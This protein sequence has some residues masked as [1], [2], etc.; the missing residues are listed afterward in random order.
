MARAG[1]HQL[2]AGVHEAP[3]LLP[4]A[5]QHLAALVQHVPEGVHGHERRDGRARRQAHAGAADA[6]LAPVI[7]SV[8][9]PHGRA[10]ARPHAADG[11]GPI[12]RGLG[13]R[14]PIRRARSACVARDAQVEQR[15]RGHDGDDRDAGIHAQPLLLAPGHHAGCGVQ[16]EGA[17][18]RQHDGRDDRHRGLRA[19][20]V[21]LTRCRTATAHV[22]APACARRQDDC[23]APGPGLRIRPVADT[24]AS[25]ISQH[26]HPSGAGWHRGHQ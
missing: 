14:A 12:R 8:A 3:V 10:S 13:R 22:H 5:R 19:Q 6:A 24:D 2:R 18:A 23:R 17:A 21:G 16:A 7:A 1:M 25:D 26:A 15:R 11:V 20:K 9:L 4:C